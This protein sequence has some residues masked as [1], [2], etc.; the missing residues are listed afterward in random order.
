MTSYDLFAAETDDKTKAGRAHVL[1]MVVQT[2]LDLGYT[3]RQ[4]IRY[5]DILRAA[6][7]GG[8]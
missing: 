5:V 2:L 7:R 8:E 6:T 3:R 1:W 4:I